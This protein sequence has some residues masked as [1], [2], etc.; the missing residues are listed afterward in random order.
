[1]SLV[2]L[3]LSDGTRTRTRTRNDRRCHNPLLP[4][5]DS[6]FIDSLSITWRSRIRSRNR[7]AEQIGKHAINGCG[8]RNRFR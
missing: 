2:V 3:V 1:M 5:N 4:T 8:Q 7:L 6:M